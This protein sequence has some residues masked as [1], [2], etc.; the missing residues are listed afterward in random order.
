MRSTRVIAAVAGAVLALGAGSALADTMHPTL[1]AKLSGMG[2]HGI[3]N[4]QSK[5]AKGQLCWTFD[6][7]TTGITGASVRDAH[8]MTVAKLGSMYKPKGCAM[9]PMKALT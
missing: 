4:L 9:V 2:E 6:V 8:G 1:G 7:M 3:V 5:S